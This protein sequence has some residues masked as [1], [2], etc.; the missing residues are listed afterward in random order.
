M[1]EKT[2][3]NL[4]PEMF[5]FVGMSESAGEEMT[6]ERVGFWKDA[7]RRFRSNWGAMIGL[8]IILVIG[9]FA[10][11]GPLMNEY[12]YE[13][14]NIPIQNKEPYE[15]HYFGTDS[16]GRDLWQRTWNGA[17]V[18]LT[19][20]FLAAFFDLVIG[21]T[22]GSISGYFGGRVDM[23]L[24]RIVEILYSIPNLIIIVLMLLIFEPGIIPI[25]LALSITGW[26]PM[27]RVV[28]AQILKLKSQE[29][30]L[31]ARTLGAGHRHILTRHLIPNVMGPIIIAIT[32]AIPSAIFFEAFLSFI[33]LG[34]RPP[35]A[36]LGSLVFD[37]SK[38]LQIYPYQLFYPATVL[39]L[40]MLAFNLLGDGL[41]DA[42]DPRMRK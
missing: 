29:Y 24:Q 10:F 31:A 27:A 13:S 19:I 38:F 22:I 40:I 5:E 14:Q 37:G 34:I 18:S 32:F 15:D 39:C 3:K 9:F 35:L 2:L 28:R 41:R 1:S 12:D 26:V 25:A 6:R 21:V 42:L 4:S 30:V 7:A 33:G 16:F 11:A 8:F 17:Q 20:A 23:V 36:S